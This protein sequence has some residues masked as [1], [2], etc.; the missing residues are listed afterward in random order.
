M[1][2]T[3]KLVMILI[4]T[5]L[6][7]SL[8]L[9]VSNNPNDTST[10][11]N[12]ILK[13]IGINQNTAVDMSNQ[14]TTTPTQQQGV[15]QYEPSLLDTIKA[16]G[17]VLKVLSDTINPLSSIVS[18]STAGVILSHYDTT[19]EKILAI[20][21]A[22]FRSVLSVLIGLEAYLLFINKKTN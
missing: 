17:R 11:M 7:V 15:A 5:S 2:S 21:I 12:D 10:P 18:V 14:D 19:I 22:L 3:Q 8:S 20:A 16:G 13:M 9:S 6:F 4:F 1:A